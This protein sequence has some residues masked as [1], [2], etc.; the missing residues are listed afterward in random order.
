MYVRFIYIKNNV[1]G[2]KVNAIDSTTVI[3]LDIICCP[4]IYLKL[5][6]SETW[7]LSPS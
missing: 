3:I 7:I 5:I 6:V 4:M 2:L 1:I